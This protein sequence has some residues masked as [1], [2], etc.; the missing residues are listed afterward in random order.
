MGM[1]MKYMGQF[2]K[3]MTLVELMVAM[4]II[5]M[6]AAITAAF[7]PSISSDNQITQA[8]GKIQS[9]LVGARQ[10]AIRSRN[11]TGIRLLQDAINPNVATQLMLIQKPADLMGY[12]MPARI[13]QPLQGVANPFVPA[14]PG[15]NVISF[16]DS[17][18][19]PFQVWGFANGEDLVMAADILVDLKTN[20]ST[21]ILGNGSVAVAPNV[22]NTNKNM[23]FIYSSFFNPQYAAANPEGEFKIIR[24][25]RVVP[26][27]EPLSLPE[28]YEII[29][30]AT[31][32]QIAAGYRDLSGSLDICFEKTGALYQGDFASN[33][34]I[35]AHK[36]DSFNRDDDA[37]IGIH[38]LSG[39]VGVFPVNTAGPDPFSFALDLRNEGL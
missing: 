37:I 28:G 39:K 11:V 17:S 34:Y 35:W 27:E 29:L 19:Q 4:A 2:R 8:S 26:G 24:Q 22:V 16:V 9:T 36:R 14:D 23:M 20:Q 25:P 6:M 1:K 3:G 12:S 10:T 32:A 18:N 7:Y 38:R 30:K 5:I 21:R 33:V 15:A 31:P 13:S